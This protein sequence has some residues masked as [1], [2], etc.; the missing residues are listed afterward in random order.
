[1][2]PLQQ[3]DAKK[4]ERV[5]REVKILLKLPSHPNLVR[6]VHSSDSRSNMYLFLE[7]CE[8]GDLKDFV[9]KR[10]GRLTEGEARY[11][12]R[13]VLRGMTFLQDEC[14]V[15]HRDIKLDNILVKSK[16]GRRR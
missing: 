1:M 8:G 12:M 14:S 11:V 16:P 10:G 4:R 2:I 13:D 7:F 5:Q 6:L 9:K 3:L 15:M